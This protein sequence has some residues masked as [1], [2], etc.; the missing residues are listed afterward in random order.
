M[1]VDEEGPQRGNDPVGQKPIE[2]RVVGQEDFYEGFE[3]F[4]QKIREASATIFLKKMNNYIKT[5]LIQE[6]T[7]RRPNLSILDL[8]CGTGGDMTKWHRQKIAHYV[9]ADLSKKSVEQAHQRHKQ[10]ITQ[11]TRD[12]K[13]SAIF[14]VAD[15]SKKD[16]IDTIL[17]QFEKQK[18]LEKGLIMFD[19]VSTQ[20][21][22]HYMFESDASLRGYLKNV[23]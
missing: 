19:V 6:V 16:A 12:D 22:I 23:S 13:F 11:S 4:D 8:C 9:G 3:L 10:S 18:R 20:F 1:E 7:F 14:I 21:A 2:I 17:S 5:L 15:A